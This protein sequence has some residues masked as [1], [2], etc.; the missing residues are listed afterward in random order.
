MYLA[1]LAVG[2]RCGPLGVVRN[3][4]GT[5]VVTGIEIRVV[6][7]VKILKTVLTVPSIDNGGDTDPTNY[8]VL[9][10]HGQVLNLMYEHGGEQCLLS[11]KEC[12]KADLDDR[13]T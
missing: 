11:G 12:D 10:R 3:A 1:I 8:R 2:W 9:N 6:K 13:R 4:D 5:P 7:G